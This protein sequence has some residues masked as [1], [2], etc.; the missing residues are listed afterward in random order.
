[1]GDEDDGLAQHRLQAHELVLHFPADE[2]VEGG[3]RFVEEP[4]PGLDGQR[5]GDSDPLLLSSG[6]LARVVAL[7]PAEAYQLDDL[8]GAPLALGARHALDFQGKGDVA[9]HVEV[10]KQRKMLEDHPHLVAAQL[11]ELLLRHR[12]E[13]FAVE[14]YPAGGRLDQ[15]GHAAH[16][17]RL[18]RARESHDHEDLALAHPQARVPDR[19]DESGSVQIVEGDGGGTFVEE[20]F[21]TV[22]EELPD[23]F[24]FEHQAGFGHTSERVGLCDHGG[25]G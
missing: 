10:R 7:A 14:E 19:G 13:I 2:G 22:A 18:A 17:G 11:D 23:A 20:A 16:Q 25:F 12:Q 1:M 24:A 5:T 9:E 3:E 4:D 8:H 15:P 6:E 21:G